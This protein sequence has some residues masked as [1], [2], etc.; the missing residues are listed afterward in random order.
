MEAGV[1]RL[2]YVPRFEEIYPKVR[3]FMREEDD[4][5]HSNKWYYSGVKLLSTLV[6]IFRRDQVVCPFEIFH[7]NEQKM[8][9]TSNMHGC[10]LS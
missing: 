7:A 2:S 1:F 9:A 10:Y 3:G 5:N 6:I 8:T 4:I